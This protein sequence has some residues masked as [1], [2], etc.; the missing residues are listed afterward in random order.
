MESIL[1]CGDSFSADWSIEYA[2]CTGW[3]NLLEQNYKVTNLSQAG[4]SEY[5]IYL[6]VL[7]V[8]D[9]LDSYDKIIISHTSPY[10][11]YTKNHP[12]HSSDKLRAH[13]D[14]L[15]QDIKYHSQTQK[16]LLPLVSY[17]ENYFDLEHAKFVHGLTCEKIENILQSYCTVH[18]SHIGWESL[19]QFKKMLQFNNLFQQYPGLINH[20]SAHGNQL[21]YKQ[22]IKTI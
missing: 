15:Y 12:I 8:I 1:I 3:P 16:M 22:I 19:Y 20:Y 14:L 18:L 7:S 10:R 13:S 6:Q 2:Q 9:Q 11:L 17:F 21:V 5:K 4:C